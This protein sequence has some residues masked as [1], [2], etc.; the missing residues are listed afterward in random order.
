MAGQPEATLHLEWDH[1]VCISEIRLTFN[2][3]LERELILSGSDRATSHT[4]RSAQPECV[5]SYLIQ[6][7]DQRIVEEHGNI[8]RHRVHQISPVKTQSLVIRLLKTHGGSPPS[9]FEL[10]IY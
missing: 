10:R 6:V 2:T 7:G 8:L 4:L 1:E 9:L 5:E 3:G